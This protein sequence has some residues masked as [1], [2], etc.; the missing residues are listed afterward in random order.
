MDP[1]DPNRRAKNSCRTHV[2]YAFIRFCQFGSSLGVGRRNQSHMP[3]TFLIILCNLCISNFH[4]LDFL[5]LIQFSI[6]TEVKRNVLWKGM[7]LAINENCSPFNKLSFRFYWVIW[8]E[9]VLSCNL[10]LLTLRQSK[11]K[12]RLYKA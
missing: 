12:K 5:E 4:L 3:S 8:T 1:F 2:S 6:S 11:G 7:A 9:I 10:F